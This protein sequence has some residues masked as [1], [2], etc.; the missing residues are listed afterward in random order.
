MSVQIKWTINEEGDVSV[1]MEGAGCDGHLGE[2][3]RALIILEE[4]FG[5]VIKNKRE[6][7]KV[8]T[9]TSVSARHKVT[10]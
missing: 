10:A 5:V 3:N 6:Q 4:E 9:S 2:F 1:N 8:S 7:R